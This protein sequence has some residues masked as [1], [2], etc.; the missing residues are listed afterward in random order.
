MHNYIQNLLLIALSILAFTGCSGSSSDTNSNTLPEANSTIQIPVESKEGAVNFLTHATFGVRKEDIDELYDMGGYIVW[1]NEQFQKNPTKYID[2]IKQHQGINLSS[3][4]VRAVLG[5]AWYSIV[6]NADDQLRQ[7]VALALSEIIVVSTIGVESSYSVA[8]FYD[9]LS[10]DAFTNYRDILYQTA[11]HPAMGAY[12]STW[13]NMKEHTTADGTLVHADENYAREVLQLFSIGLVQLEL[14]GEPKLLNGQPIPT[15]TQQDIEEFAKVYTGWTNDNGGFLY[16]DGK[17]TLAS[18]TTPMIA[19]EE[20]HDIRKKVF[21]KTFNYAYIQPQSI[22]S[23][24]TAKDDLNHAIDI[25]FNHPN[26]GPFISKQLI[27]RLVTSNPTPEYVARVAS[28]FNDN[29]SGVRGDMKSVI[30]AILTDKEALLKYKDQIVSPE[31]HGKLKEQLIRIASVMRTFHAT[32]DPSISS[33]Q[34]YDFESARY[35]GLHLQPFTSPSV[36]NYF[37][38]TFKPSGIIQDNGLVAPEFKM[39]SPWKM[40]EFG[41]VMLTVIGLTDYL[42]DKI[43]LDLSY[44][45]S[46]LTLQGPEALIAHLNLLLMSGQMSN[47]L[48]NELINYAATNTSAHD[49]VEQIIALIVLSAE[50]AIER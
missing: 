6:V 13:G 27:Q 15:Y 47:E 3:A 30:T 29:G 18:L 11:L 2:W 20:Y 33:Y 35:R 34:F 44:E 12:L 7:R 40:S 32:G 28:K 10:E 26:V 46:L 36:F 5:D 42:H 48:K 23:G 21:S 45:K 4:D 17:T 39:L 37:E 49:I 22:P 14:N 9:L 31:I 50:Y 41:S 16:L 25:I 43:T 24:L 8:D 38:P 1:L 19:Y